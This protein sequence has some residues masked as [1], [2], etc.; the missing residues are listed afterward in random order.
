MK[1]IAPHLSKHYNMIKAQEFIYMHPAFCHIDEFTNITPVCRLE[2]NRGYFLSESDEEG[3]IKVYQSDD[4]YEKW[5]KSK[6][7]DK[8]LDIYINDELVYKA[9]IEVPY[10]EC[11]E[12]L[13]NELIQIVERLEMNY[14]RELE[15]DLNEIVYRIYNIG[16]KEKEIITNWVLNNRKG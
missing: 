12:S 1:R 6:Y 7:F 13:A 15:L 3:L 5:R 8:D 9:D 2:C 4:D 10:E 11:N 14:S 16:G